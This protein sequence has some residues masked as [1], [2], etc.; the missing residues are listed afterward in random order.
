MPSDETEKTTTTI[1][2]EKKKESSTFNNERV[3]RFLTTGYTHL[4]ASVA[5]AVDAVNSGL[6]VAEETTKIQIQAPVKQA[7]QQGK[8]LEKQLEDKMDLFYKHRHQY[9]PP[10]VAG[11]AATVGLLTVLR[12]RGMPRAVLGAALAGGVAYICV[13][14]PLPIRQIPTLIMDQIQTKKDK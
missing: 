11:T 1:I 8:A 9:G 13:Y 14:E 4:H 7:W 3:N 10:V 5:S 12:G 6:S 2:V